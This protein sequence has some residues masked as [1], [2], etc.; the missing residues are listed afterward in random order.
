VRVSVHVARIDLPDGHD[1]ADEYV[2]GSSGVP[3]DDANDFAHDPSD[4]RAA[5]L[6][7]CDD[8]DRFHRRRS[9]R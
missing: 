9:R 5:G 8:Q 4:R 3:D 2:T 7:E 1:V 6:S